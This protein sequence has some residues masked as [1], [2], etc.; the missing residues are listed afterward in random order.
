MVLGGAVV[1]SGREI[2][3]GQVDLFSLFLCCRPKRLT[4]REE[5]TQ[6]VR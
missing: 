1:L 6:D 3:S 2:G 5:Q 4:A